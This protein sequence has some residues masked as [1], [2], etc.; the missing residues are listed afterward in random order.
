MEIELQDGRGV[1]GVNMQGSFPTGAKMDAGFK[2]P[3]YCGEAKDA[4]TSARTEQSCEQTAAPTTCC[5]TGKSGLFK[6]CP[7][8]ACCAAGATCQKGMGCS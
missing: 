7:L 1:M 2:D 8:Y 3:L 6:D 5:C 4:A